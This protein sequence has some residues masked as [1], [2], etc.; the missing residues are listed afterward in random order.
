MDAEQWINEGLEEVQRGPVTWE[1]FDK[2]ITRVDNLCRLCDSIDLRL[3]KLEKKVEKRSK[4]YDER[5][6]E[7]YAELD[8]LEKIKYLSWQ[9]MEDKKNRLKRYSA[10]IKMEE[11]GKIDKLPR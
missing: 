8:K 9:D 4:M 5:W 11:E 2:L 1:E 10:W 6:G 7:L 3:Y